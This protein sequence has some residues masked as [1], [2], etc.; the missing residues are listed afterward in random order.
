[1]LW[2]LAVKKSKCENCGSRNIIFSFC[3]YTNKSQWIEFSIDNSCDTYTSNFSLET[4]SKAKKKKKFIFMDN[5]YIYMNLRYFERDTETLMDWL[6]KCIYVYMVRFSQEWLEIFDQ[7]I[8][9]HS[10][11]LTSSL[12]DYKLNCI[13]Y[14]TE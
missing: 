13:F 12:V 11:K 14:F 9:I 5:F 2:K 10:I 7:L 4:C 8:F 3:Y 6:G 1:M